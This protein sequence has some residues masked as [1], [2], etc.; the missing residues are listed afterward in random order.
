MDHL[1]QRVGICGMRSN[2][3]PFTS[4]NAHRSVLGPIQFRVFTNSLGTGMECAP[5][6]L[7]TIP[8]LGGLLICWRAGLLFRGTQTGWDT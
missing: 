8:R 5:A 3:W 2:C 4:G 1:V 6:S 7:K